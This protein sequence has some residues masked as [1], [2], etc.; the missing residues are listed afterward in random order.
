[1]TED[2]ELTPEEEAALRALSREAKPP[3]ALEE[4]VVA[5]LRARELLARRGPHFWRGLAAAVALFA[6]GLAAGRWLPP[7]PA[8]PAE[9]VY[10][11][12]LYA[13]P[14][15][16]AGD[17]TA[18]AREYGAWAASL[19]K[20]GSLLG[21]ERLGSEQR[22]LGEG[23]LAALPA[24]RGYFLFRAADMDEALAIART[25][26]HLKHGGQVSVQPL[27]PV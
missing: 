24:A 12:L 2:D 7:R 20:E 9:P 22:L 3:P 13:G 4:R 26:P 25:C 16:T 5:A 8:H 14:A 10:L 27:D 17:E 21:A 11:L 23:R 6:V 15:R 1:M 19:R 18:R